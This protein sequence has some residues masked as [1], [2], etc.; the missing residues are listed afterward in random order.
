MPLH[1]YKMISQDYDVKHLKFISFDM[2]IY[3]FNT[4]RNGT[5][6]SN[7][8]ILCLECNWCH[9]KYVGETKSRIIDFKVTFL[10]LNTITIQQ[11]QD[12]FIATRINWIPQSICTS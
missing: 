2:I 10:T 4:L 6:Q 7:N 1:V 5:C 3:D 11:W 9:I 12:T 8:L